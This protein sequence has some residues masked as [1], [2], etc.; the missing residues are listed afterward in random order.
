MLLSVF[1][2]LFVITFC[3]VKPVLIVVSVELAVVFKL[4]IFL[5]PFEIS[6]NKLL[7]FPIPFEISVNKLLLFPMPFEISVNKL[8][9]FPMPFEISVNKL[10]LFPMPFEISV[11]KLLLLTSILLGYIK[12][13]NTSTSFSIIKFPDIVGIIIRMFIYYIIKKI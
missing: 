4:V 1:N 10:L 5:I 7:L 11:N 3:V 9:L 8:L 12:L 2:I 6:V 13:P